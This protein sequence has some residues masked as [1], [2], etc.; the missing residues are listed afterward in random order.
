MNSASRRWLDTKAISP[1]HA[2]RADAD[3]L[4]LYH[5]DEGTG[6]AINDASGNNHHGKI[7]GAKW[8]KVDAPVPPPVVYLDDL[9]EVEWKTITDKPLGKHGKYFDQGATEETAIIF[10]GK[11][12]THSLWMHPPFSGDRTG[13]ARYQ[14]DGRYT[15]FAAEAGVTENSTI[16]P[17]SPLTFRVLGDGRELWKSPPLQK[18]GASAEVSLDVRGVKELRLEATCGNK[19]GNCHAMWFMPLLTPAGLAAT[20]V[21]SPIGPTPPLATAPFD[22]A[23]AKVHQEAWAKHL[24]LPVEFTNGIGMKFRLIPPGES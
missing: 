21:A 24:G 19:N 2:L 15:T 8:V 23:Q 6:D 13:F 1:R 16:D 17:Q 22:A 7:V 20:A 3:T 5:L 12:V 9:P 11:P 14:L 4:A 10:R 18:R